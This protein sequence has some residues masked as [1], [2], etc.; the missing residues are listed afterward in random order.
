MDTPIPFGR[1]QI[2]EAEIEAAVAVLR[3][4]ILV[5]GPVTHDFERAFAARL[6]VAEAVA[7]SSCTAG[8]HLALFV[9]GIGPGRRV[10]VPAMT[11][12]ATAHVV[13]LQGATPVFVDVDPET[14]NMD[15][16]A[17]AQAAAEGPL[18]AILPVHYLG[19]PCDM[20]RILPIAEKAGALV[21]EDCAL[22][23][24]AT[25]GGRKA[26]GLGTCG[27][28]SFYPVKHMTSIEGG[29]VTTDDPDLAATLRKRRAFG[30]NRQLGE[31]ARPGLYD[32]DALG[33]NYRMSEVEAAVGLAQLAKL[34]ASLAAR[35]RNHALIAERLATIPGATIFPD[36]HGKAV[37]SHYC[38]NLVLP[39]SGAISRDAV[40]DALKSMGI[41]TSIHYP[42]AVPL[43]TYYREKYGYRPGQ[44]PV[45]EWLAAQ[46]ISLPVAA[47][48]SA[49]DAERIGD[50]AIAAVRSAIAG[51]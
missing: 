16:D 33:F 12:V 43:F 45:A 13:E 14:G 22:A 51:T 38:I 19:L 11:H 24:D 5:H 37:S 39:R 31:R 2:D 15:P 18:A 28:F 9:H 7:V 48:V 40:Q 6:G 21:I 4:G 1:P 10:A 34:D 23:L 41:G 47:H 29:M 17:L 26:G 8:L 50:A 20:D 44:F 25:F 46:T 49:A 42:G 35:A 32:V 27:S 3:S 30:Y 36:R